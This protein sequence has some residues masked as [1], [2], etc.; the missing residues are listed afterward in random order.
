[1]DARQAAEEVSR[2]AIIDADW[3]ARLTA[4]EASGENRRIQ[5]WDVIVFT[6]GIG[7]T[8]AV[9]KFLGAI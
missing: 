4:V 5:L 2:L 7:G 6:A 8:C 3:N 9:L 1:M